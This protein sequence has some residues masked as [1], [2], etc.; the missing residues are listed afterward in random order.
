MT[1]ITREVKYDSQTGDYFLEFPPEMLEQLGWKIGDTL[2][3]EANDDG[4]YTIKKK[5]D[6]STSDPKTNEETSGSVEN[7]IDRDSQ[8]QTRNN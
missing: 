2:V 1:R 8:D 3:W 5:M 6:D 7:I 4:T